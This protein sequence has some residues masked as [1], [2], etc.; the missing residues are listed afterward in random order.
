METLTRIAN[1]LTRPPALIYLDFDALQLFIHI[2]LHS[3][4]S[5]WSV[6][7]V[8]G[9]GVQGALSWG[10]GIIIGLG[11]ISECLGDGAFENSPTVMSLP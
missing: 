9:L 7:S 2:L 10:V 1:R 11:V 3:S 8:N 6:A 5:H 4:S